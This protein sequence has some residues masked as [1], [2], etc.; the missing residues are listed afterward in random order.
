VIERHDDNGT[1]LRRYF[2]DDSFRTRITE[3]ARR[4]AYR[5]IRTRHNVA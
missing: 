5:I 2:D 4:E 3:L 1:L